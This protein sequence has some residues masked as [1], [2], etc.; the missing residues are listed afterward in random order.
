MCGITSQTIRRKLLGVADLTLKKA[1][2]IAVGMELTEKENLR[3]LVS[4]KPYRRWNY[5]M[6]LFVAV[7]EVIYQKIVFTKIPSVTR[8]N[9]RATLVVNVRRRSLSSLQLKVNPSS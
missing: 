7:G 5:M 1:V 4:L 6:R 3:L 2:D 9:E 8:A